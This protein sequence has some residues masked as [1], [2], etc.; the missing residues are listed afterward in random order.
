[1]TPR[2]R[3]YDGTPHGG[4]VLDTNAEGFTVLM[5][6]PNNVGYEYVFVEHA[7]A[8]GIDELQEALTGTVRLMR[9]HFRRC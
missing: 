1:M 9:S 8:V 2:I 7:R 4:M 6:A 3:K 5:R